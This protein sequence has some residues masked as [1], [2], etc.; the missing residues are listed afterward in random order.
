MI[1]TIK[2]TL[3]K[4]IL[5]R[6]GLTK[7]I[8]ARTVIAAISQQKNEATRPQLFNPAHMSDPLLRQLCVAYEQE[9]K[10]SHCLDFDDLLLET[11]R[12]FQTQAPFKKMMHESVRHIL[13]DEYQDTN[14]VQHALLKEMTLDAHGAC[15]VDS[16][17]VVGDEDQSIYL[18][19]WSNY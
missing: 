13:V 18:M 8:S 1:A 17:C 5:K 19:A 15:I 6:F 9:K 10:L 14:L 11:L 12:L 16:L 3:I 4:N 2:E 7:Q